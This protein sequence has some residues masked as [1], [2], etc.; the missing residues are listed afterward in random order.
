MANRL[1]RDQILNRA[2]D[3]LDSVRLNEIDRAGST[4]PS[5]TIT[6]PGALSIGWLQDLL[7][8]AHNLYPLQGTIKTQSYT[9]TQGVTSYAAPS[10]YIVDYRNG[11]VLSDNKGRLRKRGLDYLLGLPTGTSFQARPELY[12]IVN[13]NLEIR[14]APD[15]TYTATLYYYGLPTALAGATVPKFPSDFLLVECLR[16][17]GLEWLREA[18]PGTSFK[19][20]QASLSALV[21][22][23]LGQEA[24]EDQVNVDRRYF[25]GDPG[26]IDDSGWMGQVS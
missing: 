7:D 21:K 16:Q 1:T 18:D 4:G 23:G 12:S 3:L 25:P 9:F 13:N 14:P 20:L 2:L 22:A 5:A 15:Q 26:A 17:R 19:Y 24:E 8:L 11:F 6:D 10:D